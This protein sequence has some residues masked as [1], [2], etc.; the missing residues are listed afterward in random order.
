MENI[1]VAPPIR[2]NQATYDESRNNLVRI[3][4][5][6]HLCSMIVS[7][8]SENS[9]QQESNINELLM[10]L[11]SWKDSSSKIRMPGIARHQVAQGD[12]DDME[13][14]L[15]YHEAILTLAFN[16]SMD[17]ELVALESARNALR[18]L[19]TVEKTACI[20]SKG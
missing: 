13:L 19:S 10:S 7:T 16:N 15:C 4:E 8:T 12:L 18:L 6:A 9:T 11:Q 3:T 17:V 14:C 1:E 5:F 2:T 20:F